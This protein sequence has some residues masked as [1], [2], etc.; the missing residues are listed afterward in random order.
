MIVDEEKQK[1]RVMTL[2]EIHSL[3]MKRERR[4]SNEDKDSSTKVIEQRTVPWK[5]KEH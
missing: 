4:G 2:V 3:T 1:I 5:T